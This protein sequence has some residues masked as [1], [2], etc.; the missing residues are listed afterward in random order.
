MELIVNR[1]LANTYGWLHANGTKVT[2]AVSEAVEIKE[3]R[4]AQ[5]SAAWEDTGILPRLRTG[6]G[7]ETGKLLQGL[8]ERVYRLG[9][10]EAVGDALRLHLDFIASDA[11]ARVAFR[12]E[13]RAELTVIMDYTGG[14]GAAA[15]QTQV[16]LGKGAKLRLTQIQRTGSA[17]VLINDLGAE[18]GAG[19][20]LSLVRLVLD[21]KSTYD[22]CSV[23]LIG[24]QSGFTGDIGYRVT[25]GARLDMNYEAIH[26]GKKTTSEMTASGVL[27]DG[28]FKL[29]RGTIDLRKGCAGAVGNELENVLMMDDT[30][31]NQTLPVILC[32][33]E[34]VV[35]NHG[36]TIGRLDEEL[37][38]YLESRGMAREEIYDM[39]ARARVDAVIRKIP[40]EKT[41]KALL[42]EDED[43]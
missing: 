17:E 19:A 2:A 11:G 10:G 25:S 1:P 26:L 24:E 33:E 20:Q 5:V 40:D 39:M 14:N 30:T 13:D 31:H 32:G 16:R 38:Y 15:I 18:C 29:F 6:A 23:A 34:D 22:G 4:P 43:E 36:A 9:A 35:G 41:V 37:I 8:P 7:E 28:G 21:G 3:E 42:P 12:L 27:A